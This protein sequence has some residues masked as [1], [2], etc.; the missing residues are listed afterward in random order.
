M[1]SGKIT[2]KDMIMKHIKGSDCHLLDLIGF[3]DN[4]LTKKNPKNELFYITIYLSPSDIHRF[5]SPCDF[6]QLSTI[7]INGNRRNNREHIF[8]NPYF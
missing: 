2:S 3:E 7:Q 5:Y 4:L 1:G 6:K 8:A